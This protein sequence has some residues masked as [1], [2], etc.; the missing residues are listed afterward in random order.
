MKKKL[1]KKTHHSALSRREEVSPSDVS[2]DV[3]HKL[4]LSSWRCEAQEN[5][6]GAHERHRM[7]RRHV[8]S[9]SRRVC[10]RALFLWTHTFRRAVF[11]SSPPPSSSS[12]TWS[13][14]IFSCSAATG[15][16]RKALCSARKGGYTARR[17]RTPVFVYV[18]RAQKSLAD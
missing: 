3:V 2:S 13:L 14:A 1:K 11:F 16:L 5:G 18:K 7:T 15:R 12:T 8:V 6:G 4:R 10:A 17:R 9:L